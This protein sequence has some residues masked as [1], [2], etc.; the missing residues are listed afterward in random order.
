MR[1]R[2]RVR[3]RVRVR[4]RV[5]ARLVGAKLGAAEGLPNQTP[6]RAWNPN[7]SEPADLIVLDASATDCLPPACG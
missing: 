2:V 3:I 6:Y 1:V 4:V 7:A 5:G